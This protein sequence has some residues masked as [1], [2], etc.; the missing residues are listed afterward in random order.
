MPGDLWSGAHAINDAGV[1]VGSSRLPHPV[2]AEY[3]HIAA[4]LWE[5]GVPFDL[6]PLVTNG[7]GWALVNALG[8]SQRGLILTVGLFNGQAR[9][10][11]LTPMPPPTTP[12]IASNSRDLN[13][14]GHADLVWQHSSTGQVAVWF[15]E[16]GR[17]MGSG[18]LAQVPD[19]RWSLVGMGDLDADGH[20]DLVWR[21]G[22]TGTVALWFLQGTTI[23]HTA[24][25]PAD[26]A[27]ALVAVGDVNDDGHADFLWRHASTGHVATWLMQGATVLAGVFLEHVPDLQWQLLAVEDMDSDGQADFVWQH[28]GTGQVG[29]WTME[30]LVR[31]GSR[32]LPSTGDPQWHVSAV[33]DVDG[34]GHPDLVWRHAGTGWVATWRLQEDRVVGAEWVGQADG[35]WVLH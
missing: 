22:P 3:L 13:G 5:N 16:D 21:H 20:P 26:L 6:N 18:I 9:H 27:W 25:L 34:D 29:S 1:I 7:A 30:G 17:V 2:A 10:A 12:P 31:T 33:G 32:A 14:D 28:T 24:V 19:T 4:I 8:I 23:A 15:L 35:G 11:L